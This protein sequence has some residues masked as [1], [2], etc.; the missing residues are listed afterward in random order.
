M[1]FT[2]YYLLFDNELAN[3][4]IHKYSLSVFIASSL[5]INFQILDFDTYFSGSCTITSNTRIYVFC[6]FF[7]LFGTLAPFEN[8]PLKQNFKKIYFSL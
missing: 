5:K 3:K 8:P 4:K 1:I 6:N 2:Y 7:F